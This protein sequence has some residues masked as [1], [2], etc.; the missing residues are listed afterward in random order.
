M[1]NEAVCIETPTRWARRT[2]ATGTAIPF[3]SIMNLSSDPD[4]VTISS[5]ADVFGGI[6]WTPILATDTFT[7]I[8]VA[9]DGT[10]DMKDAGAGITLGGLVSLNG[11]N[12]I[13][14]AT[15][16]E[17]PTG[18]VLGKCLETAAASEVVRVRVG[19]SE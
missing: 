8:T 16:A 12:L 7:E 18:N 5:G 1:A 11:V 9:L 19:A 13:K 14:Q 10:W 4:T 3:G 17:F 15:E 2:I 6:C